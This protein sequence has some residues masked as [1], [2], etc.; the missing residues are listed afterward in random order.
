MDD[1]RPDKGTFIPYYA[2]G[3]RGLSDMSVWVP[4]YF[5]YF[6]AQIH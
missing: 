4:K 2:W 3:N 6:G 5:Q 1:T